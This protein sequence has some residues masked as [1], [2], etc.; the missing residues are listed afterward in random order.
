[1]ES[2]SEARYEPPPILQFSFF[3]QVFCQVIRSGGSFFRNSSI[4]G[5]EYL[6]VGL[7]IESSGRTISRDLGRASFQAESRQ[8]LT[9]LLQDFVVVVLEFAGVSWLQKRSKAS[10]QAYEFVLCIQ[11]VLRAGSSCLCWA[12]CSETGALFFYDQSFRVAVTSG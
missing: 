12:Y 6:A 4:N 2:E 9:A 3:S 8:A 11:D 5:L 10:S 7:P 1:M